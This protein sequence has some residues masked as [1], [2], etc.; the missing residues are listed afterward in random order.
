VSSIAARAPT[1]RDTTAATRGTPGPASQA[2][3]PKGL[4]QDEIRQIVLDILG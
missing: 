2:A 1:G 3:E 4:S